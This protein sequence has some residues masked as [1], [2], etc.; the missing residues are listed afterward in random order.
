M[1]AAVRPE[2]HRYV[3]IITDIDD[4]I[5]RRAV[6]SAGVLARSPHFSSTPCTPTSVPLL[7]HR[8]QP[9]ATEYVGEIADIIARSS[10]AFLSR[11]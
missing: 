1:V 6:E 2:C 5:I 8:T 7:S 4:K 10:S 3:H 11:R 9:R